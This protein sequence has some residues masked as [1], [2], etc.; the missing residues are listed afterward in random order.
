[1]VLGI[2]TS[3]RRGTTMLYMVGAMAVLTIQTTSVLYTSMRTFAQSARM[4]ETLQALQLARAGVTLA[5]YRLKKNPD[6]QGEGPVSLAKGECGIRIERKEGK[7]VIHATGYF[8]SA[9]KPRVIRRIS[10]EWEK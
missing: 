10:R 2:K 6:Y 7:I 4:K 5:R 9:R 3:H 8:P 1:M